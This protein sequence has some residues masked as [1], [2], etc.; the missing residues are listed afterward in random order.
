MWLVCRK[1]IPDVFVWY[2][3][4]LSCIKWDPY[5]LVED[6]SIIWNFSVAEL[7]TINDVDLYDFMMVQTSSYSK[8]ELECYKSLNS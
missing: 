3:S 1:V 6:R 2:L 5:N 4:K 7:P 8:K